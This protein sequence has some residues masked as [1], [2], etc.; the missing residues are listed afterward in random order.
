MNELGSILIWQLEGR[1]EEL[2]R[3]EGFSGQKE[4]GTSKLKGWVISGTATFL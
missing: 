4:S 1:L 2:Y 3:M